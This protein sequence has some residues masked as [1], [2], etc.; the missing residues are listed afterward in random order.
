VDIAVVTAWNSDYQV[1]ADVTV[2]VWQRYCD[3]RGYCLHAQCINDDRNSVWAKF[4]VLREQLP[5]YDAILQVEA[6][7]LPMDFDIKVEYLANCTTASLI[8]TTDVNGFHGGVQF[9]RNTDWAKQFLEKHW[10]HGVHFGWAN[11]EQVSQ[12]ML[13][14]KEPKCEWLAVPQKIMNSFAG[15]D[16]GPD[17]TFQKTDFIAHVVGHTKE[18]K[19]NILRSLLA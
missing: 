13:L 16:Y 5:C 18:D 7:T 4:K 8:F 10:H 1:V 11:Q 15:G 9:W 2:P 19:A 3:H 6:D 17:A 12:A 14:Y